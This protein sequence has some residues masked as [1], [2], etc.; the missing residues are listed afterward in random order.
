MR[1]EGHRFSA[2][3]KEAERKQANVKKGK[4]N[5]K[6][7]VGVYGCRCLLKSGERGSCCRAYL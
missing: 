2:G 1:A 7:D 6:M 4:E 5:K 3:G